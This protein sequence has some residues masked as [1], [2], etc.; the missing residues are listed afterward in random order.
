MDE[1]LSV[2]PS[3]QRPLAGDPESVGTPAWGTHTHY[4]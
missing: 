1:D 4:G 3:E 2:H